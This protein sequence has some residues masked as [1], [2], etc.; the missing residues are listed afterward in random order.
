MGHD[1]ER[2]QLTCSAVLNSLRPKENRDRLR[3]PHPRT[4]G[5]VASGRIAIMFREGEI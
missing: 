1:V 3:S 2:V 5:P 4:D